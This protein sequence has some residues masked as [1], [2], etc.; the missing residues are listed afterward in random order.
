[1]PDYSKLTVVKLREELIKRGL[2]KTG[3]KPVLIERLVE[4]DAQAEQPSIEI[5]SVENLPTD[6]SISNVTDASR[7]IPAQSVGELASNIDVERSENAQSAKLPPE[8]AHQAHVEDVGGSQNREEVAV[9]ER[10]N[11]SQYASNE[12]VPE[13]GVSTQRVPL[14]EPTDD[15]VIG[16]MTREIT[17]ATGNAQENA[18]QEESASRDPL[19]VESQDT[20]PQITEESSVQDKL[21]PL[22]TQTTAN[23][24][25]ILEDSK[26]RK[27]RSQ[28]PPPSSM[29]ASNKR[30]KAIDGSPRIQVPEDM[31]KPSNRIIS[32]GEDTAMA[33]TISDAPATIRTNGTDNKDEPL[34]DKEHVVES[35]TPQANGIKESPPPSNLESPFKP[36][37]SDTRFKTLFTAPDRES[38]RQ[39]PYEDTEDRV[40]SPALHPATSALYIR[41]LQRPL[42]PISLKN[43]LTALGTFQTT[44]P[45]TE[46]ISEFF[47][48]TVRTHCL[49]KFISTHIA[50]RVRLGLH[51]RIW[52]DERD[53]KPLWVD[54][55]PEEKLPTW[56]DVESKETSGR[57]QAA[58]RWEVVYEMEEESINA[59]LQEADAN[60]PSQ[61]PPHI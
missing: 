1:M 23:E 29:E 3:N 55:I 15:L 45:S 61:P 19:V 2:A 40:V 35:I 10:E 53:R 14:A 38:S 44:D 22:L 33:E 27:R 9:V 8:A 49:V 60:H 24:E 57:G 25:E 28:S 6:E 43:H 31:E 26:K 41:G 42:Q 17:D 7:A 5:Q 20:K 21:A 54:F 32:D 52:P 12:A 16:E 37:P 50:S 34:Q 46:I 47:L 58:K 39:A 11:T 48:D 18:V 13:A 59:Y 4:A 51:N 56:I 30:A 36:S